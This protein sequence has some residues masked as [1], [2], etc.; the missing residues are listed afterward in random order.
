MKRMT[1]NPIIVA[2]RGLHERHPENSLAAFGEAWRR[3]IRWC[4]CD[5]HLS[6]DGVPVVIHDEML[7]RTTTGKGPVAA[8]P[9]AALARLRLCRPGGKPTDQCIPSLDQVLS[10]SRGCRMIVETKPLLGKLILPIARKVLKRRGIL[11]SFHAADIELA[12]RIL[13]S[14][15]QCAILG[16]KIVTVPGAVGRLHVDYRVLRQ[17]TMQRL[18]GTG[19]SVGV[20]TVNQPREI[21]KLARWGVAMIFTDRPL[22]ARQIVARM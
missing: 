18:T 14:R 20:W 16:E 10:A 1:G 19:I 3:G 8:Q 21:R 4:E 17:R 9:W 13:G 2:H 11:Q 12:R 7:D 15:L 5:V 22:L 6:A